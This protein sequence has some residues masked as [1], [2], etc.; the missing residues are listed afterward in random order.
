ME[1]LCLLEMASMM[2]QSL[3]EQIVEQLW[4]VEY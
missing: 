3:Q 2:L 4:E 1:L